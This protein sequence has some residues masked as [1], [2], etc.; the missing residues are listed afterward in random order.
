MIKD[1]EWD[2]AVTSE[3]EGISIGFETQGAKQK[4]RQLQ[5]GPSPGVGPSNAD[6][7]NIFMDFI[8]AQQRRD[9]ILQ[10]ELRGLRVSVEASQQPVHRHQGG[11]H[12]DFGPSLMSSP[13]IFGHPSG[14]VAAVHRKEPKMPVYQNGENIENDL[15]RFER[16]AKT[17]QWPR[18]EWACRLIP[19]LTGKALEAYTAMDE[20]MSNCYPDLREALLVKFDISPETHRQGS[21]P[22]HHNRGRHRQNHTTG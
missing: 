17:W 7:V 21:G 20:D 16:M 4:I 2:T 18:E 9:E 12:V 19:L 13:D 22:P 3:E 8:A 6:V 10:E 14:G 15:L 11:R 5:P 1:E